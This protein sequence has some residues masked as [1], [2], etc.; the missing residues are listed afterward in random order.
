MIYCPKC[1]KE[2][3]EQS[4][5]CTEC[6]NRLPIKKVIIC[7]KCANENHS[8]SNFCFKCGNNLQIE[9]ED[10]IKETF[11]E[12]E[13]ISDEVLDEKLSCPICKVSKLSYHTYKGTLGLSTKVSYECSSC[14]AVFEKK[15]TKYKLIAVDDK[16]NPIWNKYGNSTLNTEEWVR[17]AHGGVSDH[18]K[19]KLDKEKALQE[20]KAVEIQKDND[21]K[22]FLS[23]LQKG[24]FNFQTSIN[25]PIILKKGEEIFLLLNNIS[26]LEPR[27]V[28][29]TVGGYG[30]PTFRVAKGVSFRLGGVSARSESHEEL[31]NIDKGTLV[32]TNKRLIFIGSKRTTN[33]ALNKIIALEPY[34]DGVASQRE[35]KQKTEYFIGTDTNKINFSIEGREYTLPVHGVILKAAIEGKIAQI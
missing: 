1:G 14:G 29:T 8:E 20:Q 19:I 2:N 13:E 3:L 22:L 6:G 11:P 33:I 23:L 28:R 18:E 16:N 34:K 32:L 4:E 9:E 25:S 10:P 30:G 5:F 12:N 15:G 31:R 17:I 21:I 24:S 35:N 27:A 7:S 26:L